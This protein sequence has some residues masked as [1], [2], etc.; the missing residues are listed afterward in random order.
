MVNHFR[1]FSRSNSSYPLFYKIW[2]SCGIWPLGVAVA[3]LFGACGADTSWLRLRGFGVAVEL[4][5]LFCMRIC[6][7][8][9]PIQTLINS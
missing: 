3:P 6:G 1:T 8:Y 7:L 4:N 9:R 2:R 5:L